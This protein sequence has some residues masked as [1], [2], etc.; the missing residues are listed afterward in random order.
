MFCFK[1]TPAIEIQYPAEQVTKYEL[2]FSST[3]A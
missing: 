3:Q 1:H 2:N